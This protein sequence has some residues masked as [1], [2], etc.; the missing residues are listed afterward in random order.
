MSANRSTRRDFLSWTG[1]VA[2]TGLGTRLLHAA[3]P[4]ATPRPNI[5]FIMVDDTDGWDAGLRPKRQGQ[6]AATRAAGEIEGEEV[7]AT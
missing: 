4:A 5:L 7:G 3:E 1:S 2:A 6:G